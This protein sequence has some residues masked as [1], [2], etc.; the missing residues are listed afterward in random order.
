MCA[1]CTVNTKM[2]AENI[3]NKQKRRT[4]NRKLTLYSLENGYLEERKTV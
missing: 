1:N 4:E 3:Q 2:Q